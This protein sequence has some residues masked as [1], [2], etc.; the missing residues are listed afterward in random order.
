MDNSSVKHHGGAKMLFLHL[1]YCM[2]NMHLCDN[3]DDKSKG[4]I[5]IHHYNG[6]IIFEDIRRV[7]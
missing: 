6:M 2:A 3:N 1:I 4:D 5:R 7:H